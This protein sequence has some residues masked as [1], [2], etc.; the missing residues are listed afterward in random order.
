MCKTGVAYENIMGA[1]Y[2]SMHQV[3]SDTVSSFGLS[4]GLPGG[5]FGA[6][7]GIQSVFNTMY[8]TSTQSYYGRTFIRFSLWVA[9]F[10]PNAVVNANPTS[11]PRLPPYRVRVTVNPIAMPTLSSSVHT[12]LIMLRRS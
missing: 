10:D 1:M 7:A 4:A 11:R 9:T 2:T 8:S 3:T 6:S 5:I 12:E